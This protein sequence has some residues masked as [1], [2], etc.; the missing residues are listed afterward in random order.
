MNMKA[1]F[2]EQARKEL[3]PSINLCKLPLVFRCSF[4]NGLCSVS[5]KIQAARGFLKLK[6]L[7]VRDLQTRLDTVEMFT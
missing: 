1:L 7:K 6:L 3:I 4:Q 5:K 2:F